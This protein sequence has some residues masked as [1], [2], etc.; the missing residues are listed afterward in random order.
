[1]VIN[2]RVPTF[3]IPDGRDLCRILL[4]SISLWRETHDMVRRRPDDR[5]AI[6]GL[7]DWQVSVREYSTVS[8][9]CVSEIEVAAGHI[10]SVFRSHHSNIVKRGIV[11]LPATVIARPLDLSWWFAVGFSREQSFE[12]ESRQQPLALGGS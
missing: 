10:H 9:V 3:P 12:P 11:R 2:S 1:M 7:R 5:E 8:L 6:P 4:L